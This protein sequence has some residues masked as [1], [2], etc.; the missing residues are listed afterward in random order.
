MLPMAVKISFVEPAKPVDA[1]PAN[2]ARFVTVQPAQFASIPS[3]LAGLPYDV[4]HPKID[5]PARFVS[6]IAGLR[7]VTLTKGSPVKRKPISSA[8]GVEPPAAAR[9]GVILTCHTQLPPCIP[10]GITDKI[11]AANR[12]GANSNVTRTAEMILRVISLFLLDVEQ[13]G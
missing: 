3:G 6:I 9:S 2:G 10:C 13:N 5:M 12:C 7:L 11:G 4:S 8:I 1:W